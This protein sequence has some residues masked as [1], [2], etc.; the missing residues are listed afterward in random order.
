MRRYDG[1]PDSW[2]DPPEECD[3]CRS[4]DQDI[5][6]LRGEVEDQARE[7]D[8][9]VQ[10]EAAVRE[11]MSTSLGPLTKYWAVLGALSALDEARKEDE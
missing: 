8:A 1:P 10:F 9:L 11:A 3:D 4:F 6:F 7:L 5:K 2:Y